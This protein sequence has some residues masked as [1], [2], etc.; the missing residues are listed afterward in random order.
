MADHVITI[1]CISVTCYFIIFVERM[2]GLRAL[3]NGQSCFQTAGN[4]LHGA[5]PS[6]RRVSELQDS[7]IHLVSRPRT[8]YCDMTATAYLLGRHVVK[9]ARALHRGFAARGGVRGFAAGLPCTTKHNND[10]ISQCAF[11]PFETAFTGVCAGAAQG[12]RVRRRARQG[13]RPMIFFD[14]FE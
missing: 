9:E 14:Q 2:P 1:R 6:H 12:P 5:T 4:A 13:L 11:Q 8:C 10:N 3:A 7:E